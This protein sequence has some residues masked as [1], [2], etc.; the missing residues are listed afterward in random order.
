M[1]Q[2]AF[3]DLFVPD[4]GIGDV[5]R[6]GTS[7]VAT[8]RAG[9]TISSGSEN[10]TLSDGTSITFQSFTGLPAANFL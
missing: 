3:G 10:L 2:L 5:L 4:D 6:T 8:A 9:V 1:K 7:E